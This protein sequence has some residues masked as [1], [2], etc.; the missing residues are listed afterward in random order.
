MTENETHKEK[1]SM[2]LADLLCNDSPIRLERMAYQPPLLPV[3]RA[4]AGGLRP[5]EGCSLE[6]LKAAREQLP[7]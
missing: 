5:M 3:F 2:F 7:F 4:G 6:V 1:P